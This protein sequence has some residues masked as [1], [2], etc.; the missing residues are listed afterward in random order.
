MSFPTFES[1]MLERYP[2][3]KFEPLEVTTSD[4]YILTMWHVWREEFATSD[5]GPVLFQHGGLMDASLW[6]HSIPNTAKFFAFADLGHHVYL[7]NT[8][9]TRDSRKHLE[10]GQ[11]GTDPEYWDFTWGDMSKDVRANIE[12]MTQNA[13]SDSKGYYIGYS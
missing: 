5:K 12:V 1:V 4:G 8:R 11:A 9:G 6:I 10:Y 13:G 2:L 7:S 3:Y